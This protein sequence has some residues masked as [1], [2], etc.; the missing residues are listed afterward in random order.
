L[1][2]NLDFLIE[3]KEKELRPLLLEME[4]LR[5]QFTEETTLFASKWFED[6]ARFYVTKKSQVTFSLSKEKL[7][8][9]KKMVA[10]LKENAG[11]IVT[12][13]LAD[14]TVWWHKSQAL[15]DSFFQYEIHVDKF[16]MVLDKPVRRALGELGTVLEK[17]GYDVLVS[18]S[19]GTAYGEIWYEIEDSTLHPYYPHI[20]VWSQAMQSIIRKY[21]AVF[22]KAITV[23]NEIQKLK[24][25]KKRR[26]AE[27]LWNSI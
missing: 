6:T 4:K 11:K 8:D 26:Q 9:M 3:N 14:P 17:F 22:K 15:H 21:D 12:K 18:G 24:D 1:G 25:Q 5:D 13:A 7:A 16:P 10:E 23:F 2:E 20:L 19:S 27:D